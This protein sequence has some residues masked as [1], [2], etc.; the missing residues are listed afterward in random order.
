MAWSA[1]LRP[2]RK[3]SLVKHTLAYLFGN[4]DDHRQTERAGMCSLI[5]MAFSVKLAAPLPL[6]PYA[7][8]G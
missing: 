4:A 3:A 2:Y 1:I 8:T 6:L 5:R 7:K